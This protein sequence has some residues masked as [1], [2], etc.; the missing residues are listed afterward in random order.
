M[1]LS[2]KSFTRNLIR[3][4]RHAVKYLL[5]FFTEGWTWYGMAKGIKVHIWVYPRKKWLN[6]TYRKVAVSGYIFSHWR[7]N[8]YYFFNRKNFEQAVL[9]HSHKKWKDYVFSFLMTMAKY[10]IW[11]VVLHNIKIHK[12]YFLGLVALTLE[13]Q[14]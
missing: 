13:I 8:F 14:Y 4:C 9:N 12:C 11:V 6:A 2:S 3:V 1:K 10:T 7:T 5:N